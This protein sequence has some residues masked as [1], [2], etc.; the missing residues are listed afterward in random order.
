[1]VKR[2]SGVILAALLDAGIGAASANEAPK[3]VREMCS[4][5][6]GLDGNGS[7]P[8]HPEYPKIAGMHSRYIVKQ[9]RDYQ[10][11][12]RKSPV[13]APMVANLTAEQIEEVATHYSSQANKPNTVSNPRLLERG[14]QIYH[15]G[16]P[17][18][19]VP[20]CSGCHLPDASGDARYPHLAAQHAPYTY[21]ELKKFASGERDN[22]R[23]LVM[24]AVALR[25]TD[26]EMKAVAEYIASMK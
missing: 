19:A 7:Q 25:M 16:N 2:A 12:K 14:R 1:M 21:A 18:T 22:D 6:H 26:D 10:G 8:L 3:L 5:C 15:D 9:L 4:A 11:G 24:Q 23:G 13:M 20:S 17:K